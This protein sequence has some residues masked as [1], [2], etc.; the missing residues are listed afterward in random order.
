[1]ANW[2]WT[3]WEFHSLLS[4][5]TRGPRIHS[6]YFFGEILSRERG[7]LRGRPRCD[8]M[9][10]GC[11]VIVCILR[12]PNRRVAGSDNSRSA[13][14]LSKSARIAWRGKRNILPSQT[15]H[16]DCN[17]LLVDTRCAVDV[18]ETWLFCFSLFRYTNKELQPM[19]YFTIH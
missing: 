16:D 15:K 11:L 4:L 7:D 5:C 13:H 3:P 14:T 19:I 2:I 10:R 9:G 6:F 8:G 12:I 18:M 1:M 17:G